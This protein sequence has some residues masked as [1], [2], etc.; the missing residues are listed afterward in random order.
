MK[1]KLL[2]HARDL[3]DDLVALRR[4]LHR[5]PE[6]SFQE[7]RT[8]GICAARMEEL[9][10][11]VRT[12]V[13]VTGVVADLTNGEGPTVALRADMDALPIQ[14]DS[15]HDY[16]STV[17]GVMHA[18]G[19]DVHT[20]GLVGAARLLVAARDR[21]ELPRGRV[22]FLFQ[23]SEEKSDAEGK[24]GAVRMIEDGA[25]EGVDAVVGLHVGAHLPAGKLFVS[26]GPVMAGSEEI[27]VVVRG[28]S[29][30]AARPSEGVDALSLA[31]QGIVAAQQ[32]VARRIDPMDSGVVTFG[33][34]RGGR[35]PNVL[36][37]RVRIEGTLRYFRREVRESLSEAV[38][39]SFEMLQQHGAEVELRIG[40][41]YVPVVND[42]GIAET[43]EHTFT[44]LVGEDGVLP[45]EPIMGAEDFAF[46][47]EEAPGCFYWLGAALPEPREHHHPRF[48]IDEAVLPLGAASL[49]AATVALLEER[50]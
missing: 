32:A 36:A 20:S 28:V 4:D 35:A 24:S 7:T 39:A 21:G 22:R 15:L 30:H 31:A 43:L 45:M 29:A 17:D 9:G 27:E 13:G 37:D 16:R 18:C 3:S 11:D 44:E 48:D 49:A 41:G 46:L 12:G 34:I 23:P 14:E 1:L 25:M 38:R 42:A 40:P 10:L 47:A 26:G 5:H 2:D 33:T 50:S 19:H 6:L 8:A